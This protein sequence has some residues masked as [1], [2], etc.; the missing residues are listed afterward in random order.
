VTRWAVAGFLALSIPAATVLAEEADETETVGIGTMSLEVPTSWGGARN[1]EQVVRAA[2]KAHEIAVKAFQK[3]LEQYERKESKEG[4]EKPVAPQPFVEPKV[5][6]YN[7]GDDVV[8]TCHL[9]VGR[10]WQETVRAMEKVAKL[11]AAGMKLWSSAVGRAA[12]CEVVTL[13]GFA[14]S[15]DEDLAKFKEAFEKGGLVPNYHAWC[16]RHGG[17]VYEL[18]VVVSG[19]P[20]TDKRKSELL[21]QAKA[22]LATVR[23]KQ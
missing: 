8:F 3:Q 23:F 6:A 20:T 14:F 22:V 2:R 4:L 15:I 11:E 7:F 10:D 18:K 16:F 5:L 13:E 12:G 21:A 1:D 17:D 9:R 19:N